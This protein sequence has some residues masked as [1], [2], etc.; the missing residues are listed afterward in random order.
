[1]KGDHE[2][3]R[4]CTTL[5]RNGMLIDQQRRREF[6]VEY[7]GRM[8][9]WCN[10][11]MEAPQ[12]I[13]DVWR[14]ES[15][16]RQHPFNPGSGAQVAR[17]LYEDWGLEPTDFTA[18]GEPSVDDSA[19]RRLLGDPTLLPEQRDFVRALRQYRKAAK[20]VGTYLRPAAPPE[21]GKVRGSRPDDYKGWLRPN[22]RVHADWKAH[23]VVSGRLGSSPNMQ[24][25]PV[26]LRSMFIP[27]PGHKLVYADADQLELRIAAARWGAARYLDAFA[28]GDDPH[29][30]TMNLIFSDEMWSWDGAP[31]KAYRYKKSWPG[32]KIGGHFSTMRDLAKRVQYAGQ[33]GAATP[34]VHD[35]ITSAEDRDGELVYADMTLLE[36]RV[37]HEAWLNGCP[38][39]AD[40]WAHEQAYFAQHGFVRDDVGG[41]VRDC[42]DGDEL[43]TI[44]NF[45][46]QATGAAIINAAT[47]QIDA[48]YPC[49]FAGPYT[50][51]INQCHD[52]LTLEVPEAIAPQVARDL[53]ASMT[54]TTPALPGVTFAAEAVV[55]SRWED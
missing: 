18:S 36:V 28:R 24:N 32:G 21:P 16:N 23:V 52:A 3:Q 27:A 34:T 19:M 35:V 47:L 53:Q 50:G 9:R 44:V 31:P 39:F 51:L 45:P 22:G 54:G 14:Y 5:H 41:R 2:I 15:K 11:A 48:Q 1:M 10:R 26:N 49:E 38:E 42:L 30:V 6:L 12:K 13:R 40:G 29:Q 20:V 25:V 17:L 33:Y 46:I 43:N 8:Q 4:I 55:K 7:E 37:L